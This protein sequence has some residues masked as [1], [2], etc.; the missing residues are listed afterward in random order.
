MARHRWHS[1][2][3]VLTCIFVILFSL[4]QRLTVFSNC[5][6]RVNCR[7]FGLRNSSL[8]TLGQKLHF[9]PW[10]VMQ[11]C[12]PTV[13]GKGV[14]GLVVIVR[15]VFVF[16]LNSMYH[17][18]SKYL[19]L[20]ISTLISFLSKVVRLLVCVFIVKIGLK[21]HKICF[22]PY[23]TILHIKNRPTRHPKCQRR[24]KKNV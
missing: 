17:I 22:M 10:E 4:Y 18:F 16:S 7:I 3:P 14:S 5:I 2:T 13:G 8:S 6:D 9:W 23:L 21:F 24:K 11:T 20:K 15:Q 19:T 12:W 1:A